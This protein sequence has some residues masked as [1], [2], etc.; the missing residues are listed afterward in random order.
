MLRFELEKPLVSGDLKP[1]DVPAVWNETFT[2]Y[3]G[4]TPPNDAQG[5]LQDIHWSFGGIGYFP[6]YT[7]GNMYAAQFFEAAQREIG[8]LRNLLAA[9]DFM[10][11][12]EWLNRKIHVHGKR[13]RAQRLAEMVTGQKLS[14]EP[15][16]RH[17]K[18]KYEELY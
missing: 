17:L 6:T 16:V 12:K 4:I 14:S 1:A 3:F 9:G 13:F 7:L 11:L 10:P 15:L 18:T 2:R 8:N 5:C